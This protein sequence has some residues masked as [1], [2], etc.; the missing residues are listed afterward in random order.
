MTLPPQGYLVPSARP[1]IR[2]SWFHSHFPI[3]LDLMTIP[4]G[5][6][7]RVR[8]WLY[9]R[10]WFSQRRLSCPVISIGNLTVGGTGKTPVV[11]WMAQWLK[12]QGK[13]IGILSRG[14]RRTKED[15]FLLVSDGRMVLVDAKE[16]GDEPY[17][18]AKNCPGVVVAVGADRYE[19]GKWVLGQSEIDCFIL[20]DGFQHL[21]LHRDLNFL[22]ID[23]SDSSGLQKMLPAGRLREPLA[24]AE[25]ATA[26]IVTRA[27][28]MT[29]KDKI[30]GPL[31]KAVGRTIE[32]IQ[33][34]FQPKSLSCLSGNEEQPISWASGKGALIFS[35]IGNAMA[36][37]STVVSLG[38]NILDE[39][40]FPDHWAYASSDLESVRRRMRQVNAP[41]ALTT[42]KD[43]VKLA[44]LA[45]GGDEIWAVRLQVDI[46]DG[47]D[48]LYQMLNLVK[49]GV[50]AVPD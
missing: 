42:E 20:D 37:R 30:C 22:L 5:M 11:M 36:F 9:E 7:V 48:R 40:V 15:N 3:L 45:R 49:G 26:V 50:K 33:I 23:G 44:P 12:S 16:A 31:Q 1:H 47:K 13:R 35:G 41:F 19:L 39:M 10:G 25:R 27:D 28:L 2:D 34:E 43:A 4:Y 32:P 6:A 8:V 14:Y 29:D 17:L 21:G 18:M 46:K 24:A 38:V